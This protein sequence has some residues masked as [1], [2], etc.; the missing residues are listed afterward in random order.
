MNRFTTLIGLFVAACADPVTPLLPNMNLDGFPA[1]AVVTSNA[2]RD[3]VE[4][5][6]EP[7]DARLG[8]QTVGP[9]WF[10]LDL[11]RASDCA[12][13]CAAMALDGRTVNGNLVYGVLAYDVG[14]PLIPDGACLLTQEGDPLRLPR[15]TMS[16]TFT[17]QRL[18]RDGAE[19]SISLVP[20]FGLGF[21]AP[22]VAHEVLVAPIDVT[23]IRP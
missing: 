18:D 19:L 8:G 11:T 4:M 22:G 1:T 7:H 3:I 5:T 10:R 21:P 14:P 9:L 2:S 6:I 23:F 16:G 20:T 15:G 13:D 17:F 12:G